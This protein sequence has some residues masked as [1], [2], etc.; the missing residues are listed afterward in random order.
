[1]NNEAHVALAASHGERRD[2]RKEAGEP[3]ELVGRQ[4]DTHQ[5]DMQ[6]VTVE[7]GMSQN[8]QKWERRLKS[9]T[10]APLLGFE[11]VLTRTGGGTCNCTWKRRQ[12]K[13]GDEFISAFAWRLDSA[14]GVES[15]PN[16]YCV[17][18]KYER[19]ESI[20]A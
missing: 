5:E 17:L 11:L 2:M 10:A 1:M 18:I 7:T 20:T 14:S 9:E 6:K 4:W 8:D 3:A 12:K 16:L 13:R 19:V 15:S